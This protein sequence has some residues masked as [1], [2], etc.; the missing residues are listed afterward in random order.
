MAGH[1]Y[2]QHPHSYRQRPQLP[3]PRPRCVDCGSSRVGDGLAAG[4]RFVTPRL[5]RDTAAV[6]LLHRIFVGPCVSFLPQTKQ[7]SWLNLHVR[8]TMRGVI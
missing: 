8:S 4:A 5:E 7:W 3:D 1:I 2:W 6:I